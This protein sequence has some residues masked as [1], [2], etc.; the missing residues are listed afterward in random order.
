MLYAASTLCSLSARI[1]PSSCCCVSSYIRL[2]HHCIE[3]LVHVFR[4]R[5]I[6]SRATFFIFIHKMLKLHW[7]LQFMT[8][9]L[10]T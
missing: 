4:I 9:C 8:V 7:P 1:L 6:S 10:V 3:K 2:F 5:V